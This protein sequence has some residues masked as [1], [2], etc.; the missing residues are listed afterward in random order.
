MAAGHS[1]RGGYL[2]ASVHTPRTTHGVSE[3]ERVTMVLAGA[4]VIMIV[5]LGTNDV[6][7]AAVGR[8]VGGLWSEIARF[9]LHLISGG[10]V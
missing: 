10:A 4:V 8:L 7:A 2:V 3:G 9:V 6:V 1:G 5:A